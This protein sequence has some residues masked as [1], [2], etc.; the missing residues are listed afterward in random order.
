MKAVVPAWSTVS[1]PRPGMA[2]PPSASTST[3]AVMGSIGSLNVIVSRGGASGTLTPA[4][5][6]LL[7]SSACPSA[8]TGPTSAMPIAAIKTAG[9]R[10]AR[11]LIGQSSA[12]KGS[13]P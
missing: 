7:T 8:T 2:T 13:S 10:R 12:K 3:K 1:V 4:P 6:E 9:Q 5:G 11:P